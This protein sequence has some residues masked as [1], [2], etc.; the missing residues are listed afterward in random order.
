MGLADEVHAVPQ[1]MTRERLE[2]LLGPADTAE[3][4]ELLADRQVPPQSI[5]K[6]L[7]NRGIVVSNR[8]IGY[9]AVQA[10]AE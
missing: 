10:R 4:A 5:W 6:A 3:L 9:W 7:K 1:K 8:T 2:A